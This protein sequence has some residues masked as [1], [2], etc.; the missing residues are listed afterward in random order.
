MLR[1]ASITLAALV[2]VAVAATPALGAPA[3][4]GVRDSQRYGR[5][6]TDGAGRTLYLFTRERGRR[7]RCYGA[8]ADAWPPLLTRG[9][10][11]AA[12]GA[13]SRL[14][15]TT[16]RR[17]GSRQ[18]TYNGHPLYY[19]VRET[20]AGQ[21]FCQDVVEFGGTWLLVNPRGRAIR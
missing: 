10:P 19:F 6:L 17:G 9:R 16:R 7:S 21:I 2:L 13:R 11:R 15:G 8:C 3:S 5:Y 18:V 4:V 1:I 12:R 14:L 20:R